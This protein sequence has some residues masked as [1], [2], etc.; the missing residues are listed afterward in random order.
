MPWPSTRARATR[1]IAVQGPVA[2]EVLQTL[3]SVQLDQIST[4]GSRPAKW[5]L[6][7]HDFSAPGYTGEDGFEVFVQ[8]AMAG[9]CLGCGPASRAAGRDRAGRARRSRYAAARGRHAPSTATTSTR[10][11]RCSKRIWAGVV[12]WKKPDFIGADVL[13]RQKQDGVSRKLVGFEV[14]RSRDRASWPGRVRREV[15]RR[16]S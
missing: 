9:A 12:G 15:R 6:P 5:L 2:R 10:R 11:R 4:T 13:R 16:V 8:P 7:G 1:L 3:T 14:L